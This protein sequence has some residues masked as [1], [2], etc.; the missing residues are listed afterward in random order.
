MK[1]LKDSAS[2]KAFCEKLNKAPY[3]TVDTE[4]LREKTYY[5]KLCLIQISGPDKDAAAI[6]VI[7]APDIDL[8]PLLKLFKDKKILKVFHAGRQDL[9]IF[10]QLFQTLPEPLFDTQIAAMV[11]GYGDQIGFNNV[12]EQV[13]GDKLDKSQQFTDWSRRPLSDKQLQYALDDVIYLVDVFL[14]LD[15]QLIKRNREDWVLEETSNLLDPSLYENDPLEAWQRIKVK[16]A[17]PKQLAVLR[18]LAAWREKK[19]QKKDIPK[20]HIIRDDTLVDISFHPPKRHEDLNRIRGFPK[21]HEKGALGQQIF[22][23]AQKG[24]QTDKK[25]WPKVERKQVLPKE[26]QGA[27]EMLKMLLRIR[28]AEN[29]V[30]ARLIASKEDLEAIAQ[31]REKAETPALK[32]WRK[33]IF[34]DDALKMLEGKVALQLKNNKVVLKA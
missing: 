28:A 7:E 16:S 1:I 31:Y 32:G 20:A 23:A 25:D 21:G 24:L 11:C 29:D 10:W 13:T 14:Y 6:D 19:A 22:D 17:K 15:K 33:R 30:A 8:E 2:L 27:L 5:S 12:V 3:I 9:E 34:G 4:F 18:E 26:Y